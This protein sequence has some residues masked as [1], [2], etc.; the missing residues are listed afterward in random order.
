MGKTTMNEQL[1]AFL[2]NEATRDESDAVVNALLRD[3]VLRDSWTRQHRIRDALQTAAPGETE[4]AVDVTF[5][6][7][8]MSAVAE[9][10]SPALGASQASDAAENSHDNVVPMATKRRRGH[11]RRNMAGLAVAASAAGF[12]LFVT[13]PLQQWV[14]P[15]PAAQTAPVA[16]SQAQQTSNLSFETV[17]ATQAG[18]FADFDIPWNLAGGLAKSLV[19]HVSQAQTAVD[20]W[21]VSDPSLAN[22]LNDLLVE[23]NGLSRGY[24]LGATTPAFVRV[25]TYGQGFSQ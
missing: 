14:T 4:V 24:G 21:S 18:G 20:H 10:P 7:Q 8:V 3:P 22:R 17:A 9:E 16:S 5:T 11:R 19:A 1:S 23:H 15:K 12:A 6:A 13:Q 25:A 2:D